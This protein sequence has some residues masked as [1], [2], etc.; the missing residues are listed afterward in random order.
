MGPQTQENSYH[1]LL[2]S[3]NKDTVNILY[4]YFHIYNTNVKLTISISRERGKMHIYK[5][6]SFNFQKSFGNRLMKKNV[7]AAV[8]PGQK[9]KNADLFSLT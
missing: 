9:K 4:L 2:S 1:H 3:Y 6:E 7:Y 8:S 5:A